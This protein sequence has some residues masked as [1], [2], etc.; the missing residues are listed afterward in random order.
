MLETASGKKLVGGGINK[1]EKCFIL[2]VYLQIQQPF[3]FMVSLT[4]PNR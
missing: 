2:A 4:Y 1:G 3:N